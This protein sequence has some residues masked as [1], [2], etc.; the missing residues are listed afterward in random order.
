MALGD[1]LTAGFGMEGVFPGD[2]AEY[3]GLVFSIGGDAKED[4]F[5]T[6]PANTL[7][8]W[9]K[10]YNPGL[11]GQAYGETIPLTKGDYLNAGVSMAK[12][13]NL[14]PQVRPLLLQCAQSY[15][16]RSITLFLLS[17]VISTRIK[18]TS[19]MTGSY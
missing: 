15:H 1:S 11:T 6:K 5:G 19:R 4:W 7:P 12:I 16:F 3:R 14:P 17:K 2:F 10:N 18:S 9:L 8:N 13:E